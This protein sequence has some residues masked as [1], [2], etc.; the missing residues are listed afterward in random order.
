M[1][2]GIKAVALLSGLGFLFAPSVVAQDCGPTAFF[3]PLEA[4]IFGEGE[5]ERL[6]ACLSTGLD[7]RAVH[8]P[9]G[10]TILHAAAA[11]AIRGAS[12]R[13]LVAAGADPNAKSANGR[14]PLFQAAGWNRHRAVT[15]A[16]LEIGADPGGED[17]LGQ[18][19]LFIALWNENPVVV[20]PLV[21][22]GGDLSDR[23][24]RGWTSPLHIA[25]LHN[26]HP[27]TTRALLSTGADPNVRNDLGWTPLHYAA[28][29][30]ALATLL[31]EAGADSPP[32]HAAVLNENTTAVAAFLSHGGDPN[33]KD[34]AG[35]SSLHFAANRNAPELLTLLLETGADPNA[36][37]PAGGGTP[38]HEAVSA[39]VEVGIVRALLRGG[40]DPNSKEW[41]NTPLYLAALLAEDPEVVRALLDAGADP[42]I[43][44][45]RGF[46]ADEARNNPAIRDSDV[47]ER[48][49]VGG[50]TDH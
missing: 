10:R 5:V 31:L 35:W 7:V 22:A 17:D 37:L 27:E 38:L 29:K 1:R 6:H 33:Q 14:S 3:G 2:N 41:G 26:R 25:A 16:L 47:F 19:P 12:I 48:L 39:R 9:E 18:T 21:E 44:G 11:R 34:S 43:P 45:K 23:M 8:D 13:L 24:R 40:A 28:R 49:R 50:G 15:D 20:G 42:T 30:S 32:L 4:S 36:K 46:P